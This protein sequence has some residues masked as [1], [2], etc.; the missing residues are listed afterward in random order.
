[1]GHN[2]RFALWSADDWQGYCA[3]LGDMA[4]RGWTLTAH[5]WVPTCNLAMAVDLQVM[6]KA[7]GVCWSPWGETARCR[8]LYCHGRMR[9][10]AFSPRAGQ[11]VDLW[12]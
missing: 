6:I 12:R 3:T 11:H 10:R 2:P 7:K 1:M 5:C 4:R 9:F 8:R